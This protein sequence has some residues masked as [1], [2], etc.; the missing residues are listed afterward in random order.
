MGGRAA[1]ARLVTTERQLTRHR[2]AA[3]ATGEFGKLFRARRHVVKIVA[4]VGS[5][6]LNSMANVALGLLSGGRSADVAKW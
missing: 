5:F 3:R 6:G 1:G 2:R 4:G